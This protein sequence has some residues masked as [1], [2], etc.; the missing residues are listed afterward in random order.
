MVWI[1]AAV[2]LVLLFS[3]YPRTALALGGLVLL[4]V[5]MTL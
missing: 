4:G 2:I 3:E 1:F 5:L